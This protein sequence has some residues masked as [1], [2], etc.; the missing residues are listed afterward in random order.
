M[1]V[2]RLWIALAGTALLG[3]TVALLQQG[4][5]AQAQSNSGQIRFCENQT[6]RWTVY[7]A[8]SDNTFFHQEVVLGEGTY[9]ISLIPNGNFSFN[10]FV[11]AGDGNR[12]IGGQRNTRSHVQN[13]R[14]GSFSGEKFLFQMVKTTSD[15]P[16][17]SM[18]MVLKARNCPQ[19]SNDSNRQQGTPPC[20]VNY[21]Q[22]TGG[23]FG[24]EPPRCVSSPGS[25]GWSCGAP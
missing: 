10:A 13:L 20:P 11:Y 5:P 1:N 9:S 21:C 12:Y 18:T 7:P 14:V 3:G 22:T 15:C 19:S 25:R 23:I 2:T 16:G 4:S 6:E 8:H 17:C 24:L